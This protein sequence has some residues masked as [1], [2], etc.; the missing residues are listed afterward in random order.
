MKLPYDVPQVV[1][2]RCN[3][4]GCKNRLEKRLFNRE[5]AACQKCG[6]NARFR[7]IIHT[8]GNLL[9]EDENTPLQ[10]WPI[11]KSIVGVG[12][13]DWTG[14]AN[15]LKK[16]FSYKNTFFD[17]EP[18][19]DIINLTEKHLGKYDFVIS[20]EV[21]EHILPPLQ[22]AF[23]NLFHLLKLGGCLVFSVPYTHGAQT[24]EHYSDLNDYEI[25][26]FQGEKI[27]V[28]RDYAGHLQVYDN[29]VFHG[30][31]GATLEM[32]VFCETDVLS[33]LARSGFEN[34][35]VHDQPHL[36]IGYYWPDPEFPGWE[37]G[38]YIIS[39]R[40]PVVSDY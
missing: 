18:K 31:E 36:S 29:L 14:Y 15:L 12:M 13:S 34:I 6:A 40:R 38:N 4:C 19:L 24:V 27:L 20:T 33:H 21:F 16:K 17:Q 10:E 28:N 35:R 2:Y 8:L 39:A 9:G 32:R 37:S 11:R 23:D 25:L 3:I 7:G 26:E 30:G 5:L 1:E 22:K